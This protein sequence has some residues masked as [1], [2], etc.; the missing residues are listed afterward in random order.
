MLFTH[1]CVKTHLYIISTAKRFLFN[2]DHF[3]RIPSQWTPPT[4]RVFDLQKAMKCL[5]VIHQQT[6]WIYINQGMLRMVHVMASC[7]THLFWCKQMPGYWD[8][9][10]TCY[11]LVIYFGEF[12]CS[13]ACM[14]LLCEKIIE[15]QHNF[16]YESLEIDRID[17][18]FGC[19]QNG[20][21]Y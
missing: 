13:W 6:I 20:K 15:L 17:L 3:G 21:P 5:E 14:N 19:F 1:W 4:F 18:L 10:C 9:S 2:Q 11:V 16:S 7:S 12:M 8:E